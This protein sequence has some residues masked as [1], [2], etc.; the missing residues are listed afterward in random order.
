MKVAVP[1]AQGQV[2]N[3]FGHCAYFTIFELDAQNKVVSK[4]ELP[5]PQGCGCKSGVAVILKE[6]GVTMMLAGNMGDGAVNVL[7]NNGIDVIRGCSGSIDDVV[8]A[9]AQVTLQDAQIT[10][11]HE[12]HH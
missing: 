6:M 9:Y 1:T 2:D 10:C 12:C 4:Q 7:A 11:S 3:H 5:S 8:A